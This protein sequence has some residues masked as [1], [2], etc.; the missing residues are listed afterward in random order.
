MITSEEE[1]SVIQNLVYTKGTRNSYWMG[2]VRDGRG[3]FRWVDGSPFVYMHWAYGQPDNPR[4][5][6]LMMYRGRNPY[7]P[8]NLGEWND[9]ASSGICKNEPFFNVS[10]FGFICEWDS[11]GGQEANPSFAMPEM[12]IEEITKALAADPDNADLLYVRAILYGKKQELDLAI[13]DYNRVLQFDPS[14]LEALRMRG[15]LYAMKQGENRASTQNLDNAIA[16]IELFCELKPE[17]EEKRF[18]LPDLY[19]MR[20]TV[21]LDMARRDTEQ[22]KVSETDKVISDASQALALGT[23]NPF[24]YALRGM[25]YAL[26]MSVTCDTADVGKAVS[27]LE[28]AKGKGYKDNS[29]DAMLVQLY[30]LRRLL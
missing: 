8:N 29:I 4:E 10:I 16:D 5:D 25:A 11:L 27:D 30:K 18:V 23:E 21:H 3:C 24:A 6:A 26:R 15:M 20:A 12:T 17:A 2:A 19:T 7:S 13:A 22:V 9:L 14:R 1:Q 28:Y